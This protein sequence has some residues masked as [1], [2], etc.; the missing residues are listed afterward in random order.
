MKFDEKA[1]KLELQLSLL[2][3][4]IAIQNSG[5]DDVSREITMLRIDLKVEVKHLGLDLIMGGSR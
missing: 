1:K 4:L 3:K 5:I 2:D